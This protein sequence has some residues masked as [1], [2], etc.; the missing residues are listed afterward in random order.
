MQ[1][2]SFD[3]DHYELDNGEEIHQSAPET[4]WIPDKKL[5]E[6]LLVGD[7]V[8]LIFRMKET[9]GSE[10]ISVERMWVEVTHVHKNCYEGKLNNEPY[11]SNCVNCGQIVFFQPCHIINIFE[12]DNTWQSTIEV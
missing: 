4:F 11:G 9:F 8:K 5:R 6:S 12:E 2:P 1:L 7:L 3:K 10:E